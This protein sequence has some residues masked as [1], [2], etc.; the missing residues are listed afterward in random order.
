MSNPPFE[1]NTFIGSREKADNKYGQNGYHGAS[2]DLPGKPKTYMDRDYGLDND[3]DVSVTGQPGETGNW[4][5]R[6]V[7]KEAYPTAFG[8]KAPAEPAKVPTEN[9]RRASKQTAPGSFQR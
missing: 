4:Q 1:S 9:V 2:S 8:M 5:T 6:N 7:S 3:P